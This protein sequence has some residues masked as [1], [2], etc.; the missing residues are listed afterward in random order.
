MNLQTE[1]LLLIEQLIKLQNADL[2][3]KIKALLQ[4]EKEAIVGY[5]P[6]GEPITPSELVARAETSERDIAAGRTTPLKDFKKEID[7]WKKRRTTK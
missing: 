7:Q 5:K 2:I 4:E 6:N 3:A 1:K